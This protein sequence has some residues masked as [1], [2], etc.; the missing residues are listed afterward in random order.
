M[1]ESSITFALAGCLVAIGY[2]LRGF[3]K[4]TERLIMS[5]LSELNTT[6]EAVNAQLEKVKTEVQ[7]LK[8]SLTNV[9]LPANAQASLD[10]LTALA[11]AIDELNPDAT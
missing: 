6:L 11:A 4:H 2:I 3:N 7:T 8:D 1:N 10:K 9:D 5:K